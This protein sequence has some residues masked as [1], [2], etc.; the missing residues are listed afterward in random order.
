M[1]V[2]PSLPRLQSARWLCSEV[3]DMLSRDELCQVL[4]NECRRDPA[5]SLTSQQEQLVGVVCRLPDLL[6]NKMGRQ[7]HPSLLPRGYFAALGR[8][9]VAC[10]E[11]VHTALRGGPSPCLLIPW[12]SN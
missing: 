6:A 10:L 4:F 3:Q 12:C 1:C 7:L 5:H 11:R 9:M 8:S 2:C